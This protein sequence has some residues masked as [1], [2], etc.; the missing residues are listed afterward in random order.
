MPLR[1]FIKDLVVAG[2]HGVHDHE[3]ESPQR[4]SITVELRLAATKA[5]VSDDLADTADWSR[6]RREIIGIVEGKSYDLV[7]RL[8]MEIAA[9]MLEDKGVAKAVVTIDKM[10]AFETGVPG[11]RLEVD[12]SA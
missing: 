1:V 7:E 3:K 11:V 5:T 4:F 2:R 8:A 6:L 10:D 12:Q 9:R